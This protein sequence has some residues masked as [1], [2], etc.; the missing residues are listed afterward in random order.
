MD[1]VFA[2]FCLPLCL[3]VWSGRK[4]DRKTVLFLVVI[5]AIL[6]WHSCFRLVSNLVQLKLISVYAAVFCL[7]IFVIRSMLHY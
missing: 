3:L 6:R 5:V 1:V 4:D 7:G 2:R